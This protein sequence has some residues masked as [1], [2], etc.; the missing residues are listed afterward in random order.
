MTCESF[1]SM[2]TTTETGTF[3]VTLGRST[4]T[5]TADGKF[6][7]SGLLEPVRDTLEFTL[8]PTGSTHAFRNDTAALAFQTVNVGQPHFTG[9]LTDVSA[10]PVPATIGATTVTQL[11]ESAP[12]GCGSGQYSDTFT[13]IATITPSR[14]RPGTLTVTGCETAVNPPFTFQFGARFTL[15]FPH[16]T[17]TGIAIDGTLYRQVR[18]ATRPT[19][20]SP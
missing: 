12:N 10:T 14:G 17:M 13:I 18:T 6:H 2:R 4:L 3:T 11:V 9:T 16:G 20:R 8:T 1:Y 19:T 7:E 5:G 15:T